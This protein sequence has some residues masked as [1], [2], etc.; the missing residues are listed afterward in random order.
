MMK[1]KVSIA[2]AAG[3]A[4]GFISDL[5]RPA[6]LGRYDTAI[7]AYVQ[8]LALFVFQHGNKTGI[9]GQAFG[10]LR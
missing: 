1:V 5:Q 9:T 3:I 10:G 8:H 6:D 7:A 2:G 4:T